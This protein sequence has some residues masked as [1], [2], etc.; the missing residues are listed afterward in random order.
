[1]TTPIFDQADP[2]IIEITFYFPE[3]APPC[4]KSVHSID[5]FLRYSQFLSP[6]TRLATT[7]SG[8]AHQKIFDQLLIYVNL[9]QHA[10]YHAIS[11]TCSGDMVD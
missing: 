9:Y 8:H 4:K 2:K 10:K 1:M 3:F 6:V 5:S 7:I 11:L